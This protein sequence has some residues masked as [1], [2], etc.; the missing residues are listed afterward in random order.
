MS[1][2]TRVRNRRSA[3][4]GEACAPAANFLEAVEAEL[5]SAHPRALSLCQQARRAL[6]AAFA[7]DCQDERMNDLT[8][9]EVLPDPTIRRLRV[10][11]GAPRGTHES[12]RDE[13]MERLMHRRGFF[14]AQ[15]ASAIYRKRAPQLAF[16]VVIPFEDERA[17]ESCPRADSEAHQE[18]I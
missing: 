17:S 16:E 7:E 8:V 1:K 13:W 10:W 2:P 11:L 6:E 5:A 3:R 15:V 9:L 12:E 18:G 14:R 4:T